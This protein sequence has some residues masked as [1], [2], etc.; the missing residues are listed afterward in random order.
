MKKPRCKRCRKSWTPSASDKR[1]G[2]HACG[3]CRHK[4]RKPQ[5]TLEERE[6]AF[7]EERFRARTGIIREMR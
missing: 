1:N 4:A 3:S 6:I 5:P 2:I 7:R